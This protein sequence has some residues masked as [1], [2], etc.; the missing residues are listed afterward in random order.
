MERKT[1]GIK[2]ATGGGTIM[3]DFQEYSTFLLYLILTVI[4]VITLLSFL[5]YRTWKATIELLVRK[6]L[7]K[8]PFGR[9]IPVENTLC[10]RT[11][12]TTPIL[13]ENGKQQE[14]TSEDYKDSSLLDDT[15]RNVVYNNV[16]LVTIKFSTRES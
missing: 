10:W 15:I 14:N 4:P 8:R 16:P 5:L 11:G 1:G 9:S 2:K 12:N 7:N 13:L 3:R 6:E